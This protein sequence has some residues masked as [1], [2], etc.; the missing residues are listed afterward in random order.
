[1]D[2]SVKNVNDPADNLP[3]LKY[4]LRTPQ[5]FLKAIFENIPEG[6]ILVEADSLKIACSNI[7]FRKMFDYNEIDTLNL[8]LQN[9]HKTDN[10]LALLN[11]YNQNLNDNTLSS[12]KSISDLEK[13]REL[14]IKMCMQEAGFDY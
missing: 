5:P 9:L 6:I 10:G 2:I 12:L 4:S 11:Q 7:A 14:S 1:M 13:L 8:S 3:D